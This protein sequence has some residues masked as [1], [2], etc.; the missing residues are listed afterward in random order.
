MGQYYQHSMFTLSVSAMPS[1]E[2]EPPPEAKNTIV[3]PLVRL[4]YRDKDDIE[5]GHIYVH[6]RRQNALYDYIDIVRKNELFSRGWI[7]Q[8]W[9]LTRRIIHYSSGSL[10]FFE[11]L[12][13]AATD[14]WNQSVELV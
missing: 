4:T 8:E 11:C 7:L 9:L 14:E 2:G 1:L 5:N 3:G 6:R 10:L 13:K 12:T